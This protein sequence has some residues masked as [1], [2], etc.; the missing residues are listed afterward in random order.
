MAD[1]VDVGNVQEVGVG[2]AQARRVEAEAAA[3]SIP[4]LLSLDKASLEELPV[5]DLS[6]LRFGR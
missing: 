2:E 4:D 6:N 3:W 1:V 5:F